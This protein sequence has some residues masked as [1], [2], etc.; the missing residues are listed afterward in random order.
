MSRMENVVSSNSNISSHDIYNHSITNPSFYTSERGLKQ[1]SD[2]CDES[3]EFIKEEK[4]DKRCFS[5]RTDNRNKLL[6]ESFI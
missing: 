6:R 1:D 4:Y 5:S 3:N 2:H